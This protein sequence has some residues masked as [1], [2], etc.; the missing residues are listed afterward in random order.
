MSTDN[1]QMC[2]ACVCSVLRSILYTQATKPLKMRQTRPYAT[3]VATPTDTFYVIG[4]TVGPHPYPE[5]VAYF[6]SVISREIKSQLLKKKDAKPNDYV[7]A[8]HRRRK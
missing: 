8:L 6:Q 7:I 4:S 5:I 3:G 2:N 1:S